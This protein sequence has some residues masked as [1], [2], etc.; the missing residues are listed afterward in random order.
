MNP[1]FHREI[2]VRIGALH[3]DVVAPMPI[4]T[5][6]LP[7]SYREFIRS[8]PCPERQ[9]AIVN[10][11]LTP[12]FPDLPHGLRLM[13]DAGPWSMYA[14]GSTRYMVWHRG[15]G[16]K[17]AWYA[18]FSVPRV[19]SVTV[20]CGPQELGERNGHACIRDRFA[21]PLDQVLAM[22]VLAGAG[23]AL[24]HAAG[25][26][27][28]DSGLVCAG[29]SGAG[30]STVSRLWLEA[31]GGCLSDDRVILWPDGGRDNPAWRI[32]GTP[33]PGE[34]GVARNVGRVA[35]GIVLL[36]NAG[37]NRL[38][39][40]SRRDAFERLL[41][42]TSLLWFDPEMLQGGLSACEGVASALPA[43]EFGFTRDRRAA[44]SLLSLA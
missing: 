15:T 32:D 38:V 13:T 34:L 19:E 1:R 21:Y 29:R 36:K 31:G 42:V 39:R 20:H 6:S 40:L 25:L 2:S 9:G 7:D 43:Y 41:P 12:E 35:R 28:E 23:G 18:R 24:V 10:V 26:C 30:K 3:F 44:E 17:P 27:G 8:G 37:D 11:S 14:D 5:E 33:W 16:G 4:D 22:Y